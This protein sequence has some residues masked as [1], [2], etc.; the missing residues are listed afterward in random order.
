MRGKKKKIIAICIVLFLLALLCSGVF[1]VKYYLGKINRVDDSKVE[2]IIPPESQDFEVDSTPSGDVPEDT[3]DPDDIQWDDIEAFQDDHL[4]NILL[5]GQDRRKGQGRQRSD[6]MILCSINPETKQ[7]SLISFLRDL[8]VQIPNGYADNRLNAAYAFGGFPLL[9]QT[10]QKNFGISIDGNF[11]V[12]FERF[13]QVID[14]IGGVDIEL[15]SA[16]AKY[17]GEWASVGWNHLDGEQ[18]LQYARIRKIDSDFKRS[19]RQRTILETAFNKIK[20]LG[21]TESMA[22]MDTILPSLT[23]NMTDMQILSLATKLFP[24]MNSLDLKSYSVPAKNAYTS[25]RIRG[26]AV[27]VPDLDVIRQQLQNE[28]LPIKH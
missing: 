27:L 1:V 18:A 23:T 12:D 24:M 28:Y 4:I 17:L 10:I 22:L 13:T 8:Y 7:V 3:M 26:M 16:E 9:N 15:T 6:T 14:A 20:H 19:A 11:E 21:F 5:V 2:N 25:A